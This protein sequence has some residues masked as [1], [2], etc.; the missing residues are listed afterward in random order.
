[1]DNYIFLNPP[2]IILNNSFI[3]KTK[4]ITFR[5]ITSIKPFPFHINRLKTLD[6]LTIPIFMYYLIRNIKC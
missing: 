2:I 3:S 5:K 4:N 1:M 6:L